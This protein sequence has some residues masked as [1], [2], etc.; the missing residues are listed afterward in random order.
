VPGG[1]HECAVGD[2]LGDARGD[3]R[4]DRSA[5]CRVT[6]V[7]T[8]GNEAAVQSVIVEE[9]SAR[10]ASLQDLGSVAVIVV[11]LEWSW[12]AWC[13]VSATHAHLVSLHLRS[14]FEL[15]LDDSGT[16]FDELIKRFRVV[17]RVFE[18]DALSDRHLHASINSTGVNPSQ[19]VE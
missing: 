6:I 7:M 17:D 9:L 19:N 11:G 5:R 18:R 1:G 3:G 2:G 8:L 14:D 4:T 15:V 12:L 16:N 10:S 13:R